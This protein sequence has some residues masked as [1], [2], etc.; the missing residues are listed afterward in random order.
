MNKSNPLA[1]T[2]AV[3]YAVYAAAAALCPGSTRRSIDAMVLWPRL[4]M[5]SNLVN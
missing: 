5:T 2:F 4:N 3:V 1:T